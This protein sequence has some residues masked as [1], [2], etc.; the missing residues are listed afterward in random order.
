M[1]KCWNVRE[2]WIR[3]HCSGDNKAV[4][5]T[6]FYKAQEN[7]ID[8][9]NGSC[10]STLRLAGIPKEEKWNNMASHLQLFLTMLMRVEQEVRRTL[11]FLLSKPVLGQRPHIVTCRGPLLSE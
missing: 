8:L 10:Q 3:L 2:R 11:R 5:K 6:S 1:L 7:L 4:K 9:E